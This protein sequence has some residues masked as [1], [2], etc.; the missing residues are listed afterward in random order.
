MPF[1]PECGSPFEPGQS[2]CETCGSSLNQPVP[3]NAD[4]TLIKPASPVPPPPPPAKP[5][6]P[7]GPVFPPPAPPASPVPP[8]ARGFVLT[9]RIII[10]IIAAIIIVA[11]LVFFAL[12][13]ISSSGKLAGTAGLSTSG[14]PASGTMTRCPASLFLCNGYCVDLQSDEVNCGACGAAVSSGQECRNGQPMVVSSSLAGTN[15]SSAMTSTTSC[16]AGFSR[17][18]QICNDLRS[19]EQNCGQ[20]GNACRQGENC[21]SGQ[22]LTACPRGFFDCE[23]SCRDL[24]T[25]RNNCGGCWNECPVNKTCR[26]GQC[27]AVTTTLMT[28]ITTV[29]TSTTQTPGCTLGQTLCGSSC[30]NLQTDTSNCGTCGTVCPVNEYCSGGKC[31]CVG[32]FPVKCSGVCVNLNNNNN[33]CGVC[34]KVC[35]ANVANGHSRCDSG[36]CL[37]SCNADGHLDCNNNIAD[38][39]EVYIFDDEQNCGSCGFRC[40]SPMSCI[41]GHCLI[42]K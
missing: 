1:C 6:L 38:G 14:I 31:T 37:I 24:Q 18:S 13:T 35:P 40:N 41:N 25:D 10:A 34:G 30:R 9:P 7:P 12:P 29:R 5:Y 27:T 16:P 11:L 32:A 8:A 20:C 23:G 39:C 28:T 36:S 4:L 42:P 15:P 22:C 3:R 26:D 2:F 19:D 21:I 33:N 17:C